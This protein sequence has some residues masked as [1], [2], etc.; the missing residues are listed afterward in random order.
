MHSEFIGTI[1]YYLKLYIILQNLEKSLFPSHNCVFSFFGFSQTQRY[2]SPI[3]INYLGCSNSHTAQYL[4]YVLI[5]ISSHFALLIVFLITY[6][7]VKHSYF[8]KVSFLLLQLRESWFGEQQGNT[9]TT[10]LKYAMISEI[11]HVNIQ[12]S[13][14]SFK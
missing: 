13:T 1:I 14:Q 7:S 5:S 3:S 6:N 4:P 8:F 10:G 12:H 9:K 2:V 11:L